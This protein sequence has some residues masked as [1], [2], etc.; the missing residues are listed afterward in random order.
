MVG[1]SGIS[2]LCLERRCHSLHVRSI[3]SWLASTCDARK[4]SH[5]GACAATAAA[6]GLAQ[7]AP[8]IA[9]AISAAVIR[10][11]ICVL[12]LLVPKEVF[13]LR[14][15]VAGLAQC[16]LDELHPVAVHAARV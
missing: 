2:G 1:T 3:A 16:G 4:P 11:F 6:A 9:L 13:R 14:A 12:S 15:A 7:R 10:L 8:A 5:V